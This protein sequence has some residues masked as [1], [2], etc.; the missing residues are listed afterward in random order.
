MISTMS[1]KKESRSNFVVFPSFFFEIEIIGLMY[2]KKKVIILCF[3]FFFNLSRVHI[4]G[5]SSTSDD[6]SFLFFPFLFFHFLFFH[7]LFFSFRFFLMFFASNVIIIVLIPSAFSIKITFVHGE[8]S[9]SSVLRKSKTN[10]RKQYRGNKI[11]TRN[12][13]KQK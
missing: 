3:L 9:S 4:S 10:K 7:F 2:K 5:T 6:F 8:T 1:L 11:N 13:Q 12:D